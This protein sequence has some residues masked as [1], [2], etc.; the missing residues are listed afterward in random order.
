MTK[1]WLTWLAAVLLLA[2]AAACTQPETPA[3]E[4]TE[5]PAEEPT[6]ASAVEPTEAPMEEPT[7]AAEDTGA[8]SDEGMALDPVGPTWQWQQ[9]IKNDDTEDVPEDPSSY[10]L[11]L[12]E[13]GSASVQADCNMVQVSYTLDGSSLSFDMT[14]PSTLAMCEEGSLDQVFLQQLGAAAIWFEDA[15]DL[16]IDLQMDTGT[17]RFATDPLTSHAWQLVSWGATAE[18]QTEVLEGSEITLAFDPAEGQSGGSAGCN[19]YAGAYSVDGESISLGPYAVQMRA[20]PQEVMDQEQAYLAALQ[21][22]DAWSVEAGQLTLSSAEGMLIFEPRQNATLEGTAWNAISYNNGQGGAQS[23]AIG[24]EI[25]AVFEGGEMS[26]NAGCNTYNASYEVDGEN[27][28]IG[29]A[30]STRMAC[31]EPE[32]VMEQETAYLAALETAATFRVDGTSLELRTA[33]GALVASYVSES[34]ES[35][36]VEGMMEGMADEGE[37]SGDDAGDDADEAA[38]EGSQEGGEDEGSDEG[39]G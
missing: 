27:I 23:L 24:S 4:P 35:M 19:G 15:G 25:T 36:D 21:A 16:M 20:C 32:G 2:S 17:M 39:N 18:E 7:E 38:E 22:A 31:A 26:G 33:D 9:T 34:V 8:E 10:T 28:T 30:I 29:P 12:N 6:E 1:T 11:T 13:D 5:A 14:G 37:A 3:D